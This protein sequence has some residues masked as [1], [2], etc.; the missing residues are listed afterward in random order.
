ME[1]NLLNSDLGQLYQQ[2]IFT[3]YGVVGAHHRVLF[4]PK[5]AFYFRQSLRP[6]THRLQTLQS[7]YSRKE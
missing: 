1:T 6:Q 3:L 2:K 5:S 4:R 7:K